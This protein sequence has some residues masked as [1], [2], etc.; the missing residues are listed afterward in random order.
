MDDMILEF[1]NYLFTSEHLMHAI[2]ALIIVSVLGIIR[3]GI[4]GNANPFYWNLID[5]GFGKLGDKMNKQGRPKGDLIFRGFV[6]MAFVAGISFVI[7]KALEILGEQYSY[8]SII[9]IGALCLVLSSGAVF[10]AMGRLYKA[11]NQKKV[12]A[13]AYYTIARSTQ[14]DLSKNDDY[15]ITRVGMGYV[16][17]S[18]DKAVVAPIIWYLIFGLAGAYIYAALAALAWRFGKDGHSGGF[19]QAMMALEKLLGFVPNIVSGVLIC[20]AAL[21]TPTAGMTRAFLGLMR[22]SGRAKYEE[23]GLPLTAAAYALNTSLGGPTPDLKGYVV[24]RGWIGPKGATAQLESKHLH[25]V[26]YISFIAHLLWLVGL[27]AA[28]LFAGT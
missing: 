21:L 6:L 8:W 14:T 5:F 19:G 17:K 27:S 3:G 24:P 15:T 25:R 12:T 20:L 2:A 18:F 22:P 1:Q 4:G 16:L 10:A 7:G 13:G 23:G 11:L 26:A 9:E 28:L